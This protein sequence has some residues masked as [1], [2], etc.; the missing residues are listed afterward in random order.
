MNETE[1]IRKLKSLLINDL[2][3]LTR[4]KKIAIAFSGGLDSSILA[5]LLKEMG[6]KQTAY[7]VGIE[8]CKDFESAEK[9]AKELDLELKKII[10]TKEEIEKG[11]LIQAIILQKIYEENKNKPESES[12]PLKPNPISISFTLP[13]FFVAKYSKEEYIIN[14]QGADTMFGGFEKYLKL[15]KEQAIE[16]IKKDT[17]D[18]IKIGCLQFKKTAEYF[19]KKF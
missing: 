2:E 1:Y 13:L 3:N 9:S 4:D 11:M 15:T 10:L 8:N 18:L 14:G 7:V 5:K 19:R 6:V 12:H 17:G 16:K